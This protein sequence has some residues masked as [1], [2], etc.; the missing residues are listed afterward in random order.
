MGSLSCVRHAGV[1]W[2]SSPAEPTMP[3]LNSQVL[4]FKDAR[5]PLDVPLPAYS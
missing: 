5:C 4:G 2:R 1:R 3:G